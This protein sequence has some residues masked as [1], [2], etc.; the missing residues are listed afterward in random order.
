VPQLPHR[1]AGAAIGLSAASGALAAYRLTLAPGIVWAGSG[2]DSGDLAA[3]VA[4]AGVPHPTGYPTVMLLGLA[5][6]E[7]PLG[8]LALRLN[9]LTALAAAGSLI[10]LGL[11][12]VRLRPRSGFPIPLP[13]AASAA[14]VLTLFGLAPLA[15]SNAIVTEVYA[16][17]SLL[18]WSATYAAIRARASADRAATRWAF[19]SGLLLGLG[20]GAHMTVALGAP[21]LAAI[22]FQGR[23]RSRA[24]RRLAALAAAGLV[25]GCSVYAYLPIATA[26]DPP[27]NWGDPSNLERFWSVVSGEIYHSRLGG[28]DAG[29][30][31]AK[32]AWLL[33]K[34]VRQLTW[35]LLPLLAVGG[36]SLI[37][38]HG[39]AALATGWIALSALVVGALY[40]SRDDEVFLLPALAASALWSAVGV[41]EIGR[42]ASFAGTGTRRLVAATLAALLVTTTLIRGMEIAPDVSMRDAT[43][44]AAFAHAVLAQASPKSVILTDDDRAT[45]PLWY[46]RHAPGGRSDVTIVDQRLWQFAWYREMLNRQAAI[47]TEVSPA[48]LL[49]AGRWPSERPLWTVDIKAHGARSGDVLATVRILNAR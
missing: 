22:L 25:A 14:A 17:A 32:A 47:P 19:A 15:W 48:S 24:A 31:A 2:I 23:W 42:R 41:F 39:W 9:V 5:V 20:M 6:R 37:R 28:S 4:V 38:R 40:S 44:A 46:A 10:P 36:A 16:L 7:I 8:D 11:L 1:F 35:V 3:A 29:A 49:A 13:E 30:I 12:A 45:F 18:L 34:P 26:L 27:I 43:H 33:G 21:A